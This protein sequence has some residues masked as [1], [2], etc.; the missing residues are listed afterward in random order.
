MRA[1]TISASLL[2]G[3]SVAHAQEDGALA[4]APVPFPHPSITEV[5]FHVPQ[6]SEGDP[7]LDG[8]RE[9]V[10]DE[11]IE[12]ANLHDRAIDLGGYTL[13]DRGA[14]ITFTFPA[15]KLEPGAIAVV[16][17][18]RET[19]IPGPVGGATTVPSERNKNFN[20]AW[21]FNLGNTSRMKALN[22]Q[23]DM[24]MLSSPDGLPVDIIMWGASDMRDWTSNPRIAFVKPSPKCSVQRVRESGELLPH[25]DIDGAWFS[26]GWIPDRVTVADADPE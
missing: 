1:L 9:A 18:G 10:G 26:P 4:N 23:N 12:I 21:V 22:N 7:S 5:L 16:F 2:L 19:E 25:K 14:Q 24:V 20:N 6:D 11:F 17:N 15:M 8:V 13:S 3:A